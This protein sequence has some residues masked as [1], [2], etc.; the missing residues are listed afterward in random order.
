MNFDNAFIIDKYFNIW[1]FSLAQ[2]MF[3]VI[4]SFDDFPITSENLD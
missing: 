4:S 2:E 1:P 3:I